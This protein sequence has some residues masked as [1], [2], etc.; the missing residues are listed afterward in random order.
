MLIGF[1]RVAGRR[2]TSL[3]ST[4]ETD[5]LIRRVL[6]GQLCIP[7]YV[8]TKYI[9]AYNLLLSGKVMW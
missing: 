8:H 3:Y 6:Y 7:I 2:L 4:L 9:I 5:G 1:G